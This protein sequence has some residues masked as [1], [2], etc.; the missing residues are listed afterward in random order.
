MKFWIGKTEVSVMNSLM[1]IYAT[2]FNPSA[3]MLCKTTG[4][5][6]SLSKEQISYHISCHQN[7][8]GLKLPNRLIKGCKFCG[9]EGFTYSWGNNS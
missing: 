2:T 3:K 5:W 1:E 8:R 7:S 6:K 4:F 9:V